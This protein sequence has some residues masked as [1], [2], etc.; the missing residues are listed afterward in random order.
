MDFYITS[1][2]FIL[3]NDTMIPEVSYVASKYRKLKLQRK[4]EEREERL[5]FPRRI[6][7]TVNSL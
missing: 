6:A 2:Y 5:S 7:I 1:E 4:K 3:G